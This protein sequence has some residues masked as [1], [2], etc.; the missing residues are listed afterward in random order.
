[1]RGAQ[2]D[3]KRPSCQ[4]R[5][6]ARRDRAPP[7]KALARRLHARPGRAA[8][9]R[10]RRRSPAAAPPRGRR[11]RTWPSARCRSGRAMT[12][13]P[14]ASSSASDVALRQREGRT[15]PGAPLTSLRP[16]RS[17]PRATTSSPAERARGRGAQRVHHR[18]DAPRRRSRPCRV[19]F[20]CALVKTPQR[21]ADGVERGRAASRR[22]P[23]RTAASSAA[24][25]GGG[26]AVLVVHDVAHAVAERLFVAEDELVALAL[27]R[28]GAVGD[29]LEAGERLLVADAEVR[30]DAPEQRRRHDRREDGARPGRRLSRSGGSAR[31]ARRPRC[32]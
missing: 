11:S 27:E 19:T 2:N 24:S 29:P 17:R 25:S 10:P 18:A 3:G 9:A 7:E 28:D 8:R 14:D 12:R 5:R 26:D 6:P 4:G 31:A 16:A 21:R 30:G 15:Q 1:M 32:P 23:R 13:L 20:T 22:A